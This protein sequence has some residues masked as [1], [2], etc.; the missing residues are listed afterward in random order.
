MR[1]KLGGCMFLMKRGQ[2]WRPHGLMVIFQSAVSLSQPTDTWSESLGCSRKE[3]TFIISLG[4]VGETNS[5]VAKKM[6]RV[7]SCKDRSLLMWNSCR[8]GLTSCALTHKTHTLETAEARQR[9][10]WCFS[11]RLSNEI[12]YQTSPASPYLD[13]NT[14][15]VASVAHCVTNLN[16]S[17]SIFTPPW[18][19]T[20]FTLRVMYVF[21]LF[22]IPGRFS[23]QAVCGRAGWKAQRSYSPDV[24]H[25]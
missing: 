19:Q 9:S 11:S 5:K 18:T 15:H 7:W 14:L 10:M 24:N 20:K 16:N 12:P 8:G 4:K 1:A 23:I 6:I 17:I 25:K 13:D 2:N 21:L 3:K 22:L